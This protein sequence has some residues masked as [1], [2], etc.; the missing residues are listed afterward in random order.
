LP[1]SSSSVG[2]AFRKKMTDN[3]VK[4][5]LVGWGYGGKT[6]HASL[7]F[8]TSG[9]SLYGIVSSQASLTAET[10]TLVTEAQTAKHKDELLKV[11][12]F[13]TLETALQDSNV[14]V[15]VVCNASGAHYECGMQSLK[16]G[17]HV[18][19]DKPMCLRE[20]EAHEMIKL[21]KEQGKI[22]TV[23]HNRRFDGDYN[24]VKSLIE[25]ENSRLD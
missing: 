25:E 1:E 13:K 16:A 2:N 5:V 17:K 22:L 6:I 14:D 19:V 15:V 9:I 3:T 18:V 12:I 4:A 8:K 20:T 21:A 7:I 23:F 11:K 24:T 10:L